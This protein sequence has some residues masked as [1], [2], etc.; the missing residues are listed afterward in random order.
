MLIVRISAFRKK[1]DT[2]LKE[3]FLVGVWGSCRS[4]EGAASF[5][6]AKPRRAL[7]FRPSDPDTTAKQL[8]MGLLLNPCQRRLRL[9][10]TALVSA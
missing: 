3:F 7:R 9:R 6:A 5:R 8:R 2:I 1:Y 4:A 10:T